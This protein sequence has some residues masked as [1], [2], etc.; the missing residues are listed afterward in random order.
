MSVNIIKELKSSGLVKQGNME[1][2]VS[3]ADEK[4]IH[5][6][7]SEV[8]STGNIATTVQPMHGDEEEDLDKEKMSYQREEVVKTCE[9]IVKVVQELA[10]VYE[11]LTGQNMHELYCPNCKPYDLSPS[12]MPDDEEP[13]RN[14]SPEGS[15]GMN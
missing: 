8:T 6:Q 13:S 10:E 11:Q 2:F 12:R 7:N 5:N 14:K 9:G 4:E 3:K 15:V 1:A